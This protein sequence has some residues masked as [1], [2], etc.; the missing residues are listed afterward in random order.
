MNDLFD[1]GTDVRPQEKDVES[2]TVKGSTPVE[3]A[4][5]QGSRRWQLRFPAFERH[6]IPEHYD[7]QFM[8]HNNFSYSFFA[9][10]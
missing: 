8:D 4:S 1:L 6:L 9:A 2:V 7:P 5:R 10:F 3:K